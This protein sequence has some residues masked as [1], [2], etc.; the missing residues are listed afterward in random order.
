VAVYREIIDQVIVLNRYVLRISGMCDERKKLPRQF[1]AP[2]LMR[3][4]DRGCYT[5]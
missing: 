2:G 3:R 4:D 5:K 1:G